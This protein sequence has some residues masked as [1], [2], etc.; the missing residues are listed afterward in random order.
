M[1]AL[2]VSGVIAGVIGIPLAAACY[3]YRRDK[4]RW[5]ARFGRPLTVIHPG[6]WDG[7][8]GDTIARIRH[9]LAG[10]DDD[11]NQWEAEWRRQEDGRG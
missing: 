1:S 2:I 10:Y 9:G 6:E 4:A 8:D 3:V 7:V 5:N 11:L